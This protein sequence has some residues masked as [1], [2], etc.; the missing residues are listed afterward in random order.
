MARGYGFTPSASYLR[1]GAGQSPL[2]RNPTAAQQ[3]SQSQAIQQKWAAN[4]ARNPA[5]TSR[6]ANPWRPGVPGYFPGRQMGPRE[7][8]EERQRALQ[9]SRPQPGRQ[10][11]DPGIAD[12]R[13][14]EGEL[15]AWQRG[16]YD[17][18]NRQ[19]PAY[20]DYGPGN[21]GVQK[22][23]YG[24]WIGKP[25]GERRIR[26][27]RD[28]DGDGIDDRNQAGPGQRPPN[29]PAPR[30]GTAQPVQPPSLGTPYNPGQPTVGGWPDYPQPPIQSPAPSWGSPSQG[31]PQ[32]PMTQMW[33]QSMNAWAM[34]KQQLLGWGQQMQQMPWGPNY[35]NTP[36]SRPSPWSQQV[37]GMFGNN[38]QDMWN[39]IGGFIQGVNSQAAQKPVGVY[40]GQGN[41][42]PQ[43]GK[44]TYDIR[45]LINQGNQMVQG[46][47]QNPFMQYGSG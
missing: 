6:A 28:S 3:A 21:P 46:G 37:T 23:Q 34:P 7:I 41:P 40:Q 25:A 12:Q 29:M 19:T 36:D 22:P 11:V 13:R 30:P 1:Q 15:E 10:P 17:A 31:M 33:Q 44:Q 24:A 18:V 4:V 27:F 9:A 32:D 39:N 35:A 14:Q 8:Y 26:D 47:W 16:G 42:G 38:Q 45:S 20:V 2:T 43:Y 5:P